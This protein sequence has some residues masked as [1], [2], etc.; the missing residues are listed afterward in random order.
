MNSRFNTGH[1]SLVSWNGRQPAYDTAKTETF[2]GFNHTWHV[3]QQQLNVGFRISGTVRNA[4]GSI[5]PE[6]KI[7]ILCAG[8]AVAQCFGISN[9]RYSVQLDLLKLNSPLI[10]VLVMKCGYQSCREETVISKTH[11]LE[12]DIVL[13]ANTESIDESFTDSIIEPEKIS[14]AEEGIRQ[15]T[16]RGVS[17]QVMVNIQAPQPPGTAEKVEVK[18]N[19][20]Y[21]YPNPVSDK[22][23]VE[24]ETASVYRFQ[25]FN[26]EGKVLVDRPF[27]GNSTIEDVS[28]L[29]P[30]NYIANVINESLGVMYSIKLTVMR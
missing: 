20:I 9:G 15:L 30:G 28:H 18:T 29:I 27:T 24:M 22:L 11:H 2:R 10:S 5:I 25:I 23:N 4:E 3:S 17:T 19:S 21:V 13:K 12:K 6:A 16:M 26:R 7:I 8:K 1:P 14:I